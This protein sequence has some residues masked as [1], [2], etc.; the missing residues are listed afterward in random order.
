MPAFTWASDRA[1]LVTIDHADSDETHALVRASEQAIMLRG[2]TGIQDIVAAY[3]SL[4]VLWP[5]PEIDHAEVERSV[6]ACVEH[7]GENPPSLTHSVTLPCCYDDAFAPDLGEVASLHAMTRE[8][9]IRP[10]SSATYTVR[11]LGFSPGFPYMAGLPECLHTP[12]LLSPRTRVP[13]GSIAIAGSQAGIYPQSTPG[14]W[15]I[16][17]RTPAL[18]FDPAHTPHTTL[19]MGTR[20][21]FRPISA[22]EFEAFNPREWGLRA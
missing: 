15:R 11:F 6:R 3:A 1:L 2:P 4:L 10:H 7:A 14:G 9:V 22:R 18:I 16:L 19:A 17:G 13:A 8:E 20:I 21:R 5:S 12:R